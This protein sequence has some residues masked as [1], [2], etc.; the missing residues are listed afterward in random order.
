MGDAMWFRVGKWHWLT[1]LG[2]VWGSFAQDLAADSWSLAPDPVPE[3]VQRPTITARSILL[4]NA[5]RQLVVPAHPSDHVLVLLGTDREGLVYSLS[6]GKSV[7]RV[8]SAYRSTEFGTVALNVEGTCAAIAADHFTSGAVDVW[9]TTNGR[10]I[11]RLEPGAKARRVESLAFLGTTSLATYPGREGDHSLTIWDVE[12]GEPLRTITTPHPLE[13]GVLAV[14]PGGKYLAVAAQYKNFVMIYDIET[15]RQLALISF[16]AAAGSWDTC[17]GLAFSPD[18][19]ELA[20]LYGTQPSIVRV[21]KLQEGELT[22]ERQV[23]ADPWGNLRGR[24]SYTGQKFT[25]I[26][27]G[28]GWLCYGFYWVRRAEMDVVRDFE[29][30]NN[31]LVTTILPLNAR[32]VV[33]CTRE[34]LKGRLIV[35][36]L[37][38]L[39]E[40]QADE[41]PPPL[42]NKGASVQLALDVKSVRHADVEDVKKKLE[43]GLTLRLRALGLNVVDE[44]PLTLRLVYEEL[45]GAPMK[46]P[47]SN[48]IR[49]LA[50]PVL[51]LFGRPGQRPGQ[52]TGFV[53]SP[54]GHVA[55]C[56]H[57]IGNAQTMSVKLGKEIHQAKVLVKDEKLDLALLKFD[58][59]NL[60]FLRFRD[61]DQFELGEDLRA[62]GYPLTDVLG[63]TMKVT[64]GTLS[65]QIRRNDRNMFMTDVSTN[66]GNSGGP[67]IDQ[68]GRVLAISTAIFV[69]ERIDKISLSA[70]VNQLKALCEGQKVDWPLATA[71]QPPVAGADL[72][73]L[74]ETTVAML[75][76]PGVAPPAPDEAEAEATD[77]KWEAALYVTDREEPVW[78]FASVSKSGAYA[79]EGAWN[80]QSLRNSSARHAELFINQLSLPSYISADGTVQLPQRVVLDSV[81]N[82]NR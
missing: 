45:A 23:Q 72:V 66:P 75:L 69:G 43:R 20:G 73:K 3:A 19:T 14:S 32:Q 82:E 9:E 12:S 63:D 13:K 11:A 21:W 58:G 37:A 10:L 70:P 65:G 51:P 2:L 29:V 76:P 26:P 56:A 18:G 16:K 54:T 34:S 27:D 52:G 74:L 40:P 81:S 42:L 59:E 4:P 57:V 46:R 49:I 17:H 60:P 61:S 30:K 53:I 47:Q 36:E 44:A 55:T 28:S 22:I 77:T 6:Q 38:T 67:L 79:I 68:H 41:T 33:Y 50:P 24:P 80:A 78:K 64:K 62:V 1:I 25:W 31:P 48:S 15:G 8:T 35:Q 39:P 71:E 5:A 7:G